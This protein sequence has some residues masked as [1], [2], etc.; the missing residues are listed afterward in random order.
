[1][2]DLPAPQH[3]PPLSTRLLPTLW[4]WLRLAWFD[5]VHTSSGGVREGLIYMCLVGIGAL[6]VVSAIN[7]SPVGGLG[8]PRGLL[9]LSSPFLASGLLLLLGMYRPREQVL[10]PEDLLAV[11]YILQESPHWAPQV[12]A[13]AAANEGRLDQRHLRALAHAGSPRAKQV[14]QALGY[15]PEALLHRTPP[16]S[17]H[18]VL[19][20]RMGHL[21]EA[22]TLDRHT[23]SAQGA[24]RLARL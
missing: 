5:L 21:L 19:E 1:M 10:S 4:R 17:L 6:F 15:F 13:W 2:H 20:G 24:H 9:L 18:S 7:I 8:T 11:E 23:S 16:A 3:F 22:S 12:A 14:R